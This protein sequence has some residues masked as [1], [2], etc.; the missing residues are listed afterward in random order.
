MYEEFSDVYDRLMGN[1]PYDEWF[2]KLH[3]YLCQHGIREG[4]VCEL[5]CGT[6]S[7]TERFAKAGY[8]MIGVDLSEDML[9]L[10]QRKKEESGLDILY[11]HQNME[12]LE[13]LSLVDAIISVCDSM[14]YLL[15]ETALDKVFANVRKYLKDDGYFIFDMKTEY[16]Y[17]NV[18]GNRTWAD[19]DED[20]ACIWEND[21]DEKEKINEYFVTVFKKMR[22]RNFYE[23][24]EEVHY[25]RAYAVEEIRRLLEKNG[26]I[27]ADCF[28]E[29]MEGNA[30]DDSERIYVVAKLPVCS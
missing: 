8:R 10:A 24:F 22:D 7:M 27:M 30:G 21:Y 25:Q 3:H 16:C 6:G 4:T 23:R 17:R 29:Q 13:L 19:M 5:G 14:N 20:V 15:D 28:G 1:I 2:E 18:I 26:M 9:A 12:E 11:L